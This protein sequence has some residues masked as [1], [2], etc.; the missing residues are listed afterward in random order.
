MAKII[1]LRDGIEFY[2]DSKG[3]E[4]YNTTLTL[5]QL[6]SEF[7]YSTGNHK[8]VSNDNVLFLIFNLPYKVT[9]PYRTKSC[10]ALC[11]AAKSEKAYPDCN[12]SRNRNLAFSKTDNFVPYMIELIKIKLNNL[13]P[14]RKIIFRIHESGDFYNRMYTRKWILI[15]NYFSGDNRIKFVAYTKSVI[16]FKGIDL[17]SMKNF[18]L[19]YSLWADT[20]PEQYAIA[21][22]LQLP[23][24]TALDMS[25]I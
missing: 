5:K 10:E 24:Y 22:E 1:Y 25:N 4:K 17:D 21:K 14:G 19:R 2:K 11:Y 23:T 3:N 13:K 8:L 12:P 15:I 16:F 9:C 7:S 6:E 18:T 20:S